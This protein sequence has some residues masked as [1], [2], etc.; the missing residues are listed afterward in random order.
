MHRIFNHN[1]LYS[2]SRASVV[3]IFDVK[4]LLA[5][6]ISYG[7]LLFLGH[8]ICI[9]FFCSRTNELVD[10]TVPD[11]LS[12]SSKRTCFSPTSNRRCTSPIHLLYVLFVFNTSNKL[13]GL[14][15]TIAF[16]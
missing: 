6:I 4:I 11:S 13:V 10:Y 9:M 15:V 8:P 16:Y 5:V 7:G 2:V 12:S 3:L 1:R 14:I